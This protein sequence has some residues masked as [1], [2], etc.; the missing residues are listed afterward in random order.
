[1]DRGGEFTSHELNHFC[2]EESISHML[3]VLYSPQQN[4]IVERKY[5]SIFDM[6]R[7]L[8]KGKDIPNQFWGEA[9]HHTT[10]F[11]NHTPT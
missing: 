10:Y 11:I 3:T 9:I 5:W 2:D 1:M 8:M 6:S 4:N 7:C